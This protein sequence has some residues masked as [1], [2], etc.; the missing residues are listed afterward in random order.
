MKYLDRV[1]ILTDDYE[2]YGIRKGD[3]G[4]IMNPEIRY[5]TFLFFRENPETL[6]DDADADVRIQDMEVVESSNATDEDILDALPL[7]NPAWGCKVENGYI[8]DLNGKRQNQYA[9]N[10]AVPADDD[11]A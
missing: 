5:G 10:Y 11:K 3:E 2:E 4:H 9:Y 7:H 1:R 8:L 6:E